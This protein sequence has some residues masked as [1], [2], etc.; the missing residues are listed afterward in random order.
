MINN[1][2]SVTATTSRFFRTLRTAAS[3]A[4]ILV[5][6]IAALG[7]Q[8][9]VAAPKP[10]ISTPT[11]SCAGATQTSINIQVCAGATGLPGGFTLQWL[12]AADYA[13]NGNQWLSDSNPL[14]CSAGF[15]GEANLSRYNLAP[16][17]CVTVNVGDFLFDNGA[18]TN[19]PTG[20]QCGT[21]YVFRAFGHATSTMS[22]S[23]F[24]AITTCATL[25]CGHASSCTLTQGYWKTHG[26]VPN[27]NNAYV[28]PDPIKA[29]GLHLGN[30]AYTPADILSI[31]NKPAAGNGLIA[32][33][34]Q[35]IAAKLNVAA[36]AD[37]TAIAADIATADALIGNLIVP[38]LGSGYLAPSLTSGL[39]TVL[40]NYNEGA[41][42]PGHC[43]DQE[44]A[45]AQ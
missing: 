30:I 7:A 6:F 27:G 21:Q 10:P 20:L 45:T 24:T 8:S 44:P 5:P 26:P 14:A 39:V 43:D 25:D 32:L 17:E 33:A 18:S 19:C 1:A 3:N 28:W 35:L 42:G 16:G 40:G 41:T 15:A 38:P 13:A 29:S 4:W 22:R 11:V 34:H 31:L 12:K 9:A 23:A 36:G 37:P 2:E